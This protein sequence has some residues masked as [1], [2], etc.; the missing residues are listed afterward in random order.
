LSGPVAILS[1]D[2][3]EKSFRE[4]TGLLRVLDKLSLRVR[5]G[6]IVLLQGPSGSGKTTLLQIAGCLLRADA[7]RVELEGRELNSASDSERTVAR[8][9]H[10]G[11]AFQSFHLVDALTVRDNV[12]LGLRLKRQPA[13]AR[14]VNEM[15]ELL[16]ISRQA[17]KLPRDLSGGEKQRVAFAR[18]LAGRP[19]LL[20]ADE[21]TS[22]LDSHAAESVGQLVRLSVRESGSAALITTHDSRLHRIADRLCT[23]KEGRIHE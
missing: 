10:L 17:D 1:L 14:R 19:S 20:L 3:V 18:A 2:A 21:P 9:N 22:Q 8:Q 23:M 5:S 15:L 4:P 6:E 11:F 16:G 13:S 7:G 12:T